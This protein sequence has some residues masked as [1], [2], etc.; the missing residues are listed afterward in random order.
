MCV[1]ENFIHRIAGR[2]WAAIEKIQAD[3]DVSIEL[4]EPITGLKER[5]VA[6]FGDALEN[7]SESVMKVYATLESHTS[8]PHSPV[9]VLGSPTERK[10]GEII[11]FLVT[12]EEARLLTNE[13]VSFAA[14]MNQLYGVDYKILQ[15]N[16]RAN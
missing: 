5:I 15:K 6:I 14:K 10:P 9:D 1:P 8:L 4:Q 7:I 2:N 11:R 13:E 12:E 16:C 3:L